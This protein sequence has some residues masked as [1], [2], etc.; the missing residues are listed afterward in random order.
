MNSSTERFFKDVYYS[1]IGLR[2]LY[3]LYE[4]LVDLNNYRLRL[5]EGH[6]LA[7]LKGNKNYLEDFWIKPQM[8]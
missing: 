6:P 8:Q 1:S 7:R 5:N 3:E 4:A 2:G